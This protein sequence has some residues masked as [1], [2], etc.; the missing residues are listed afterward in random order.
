MGG[1]LGYEDGFEVAV[2]VVSGIH[3][4]EQKM[5]G[6]GCGVMCGLLGK[7]ERVGCGKIVQCSDQNYLFMNPIYLFN[8]TQVI[9]NLSG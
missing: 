6:K 9:L 5:G 4:F 1:G 2:R 3:V 8:L 7:V